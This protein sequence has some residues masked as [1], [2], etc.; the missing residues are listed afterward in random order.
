MA[1]TFFRDLAKKHLLYK[2]IAEDLSE[3][4]GSEEKVYAISFLVKMGWPKE[5]DIGMFTFLSTEEPPTMSFMPKTKS[6]AFLEDYVV[7]NPKNRMHPYMQVPED[8]VHRAMI[9]TLFGDDEVEV[10]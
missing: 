6:D 4:M 2:W 8:K 5:N 1:V 10:V 9:R 7:L 3:T